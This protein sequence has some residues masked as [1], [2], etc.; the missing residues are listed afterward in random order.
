[1]RYGMDKPHMTGIPSFSGMEPKRTN[2]YKCDASAVYGAK[3]KSIY[4]FLPT[5]P[6]VQSFRRRADPKS[7]IKGNG[8]MLG[9]GLGL[10]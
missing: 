6:G 7:P 3:P 4:K 8:C 5:I 2:V 10:V 1:M 9:L